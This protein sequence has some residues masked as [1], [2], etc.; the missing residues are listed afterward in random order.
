MYLQTLKN[1]HKFD[2]EKYEN[3]PEAKKMGNALEF[4]QR[5]MAGMIETIPLTEEEKRKVAEYKN[6]ECE[7]NSNI[8]KA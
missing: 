6:K 4:S 2:V 1:L 7:R 8:G 5:Y 3:D